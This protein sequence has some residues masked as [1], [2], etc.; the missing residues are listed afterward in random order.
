MWFK[1]DEEDGVRVA[2]NLGEV[3]PELGK[4]GLLL[5]ANWFSEGRWA[6]LRGEGLAQL[7]QFGE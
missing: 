4:H 1:I 3:N 6:K 7:P 2:F 5:P